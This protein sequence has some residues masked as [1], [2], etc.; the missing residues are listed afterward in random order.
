MLSCSSANSLGSDSQKGLTFPKEAS[1]SAV[2][3]FPARKRPG[4]AR[5]RAGDLLL[6]LPQHSV[7]TLLFMSN[8]EAGI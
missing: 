2:M 3:N 4:E 1:A 7:I 5:T 6:L 8:K